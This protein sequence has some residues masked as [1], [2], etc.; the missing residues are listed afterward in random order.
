ML[1]CGRSADFDTVSALRSDFIRAMIPI[2][3]IL[4]LVVTVI[5]GGKGRMGR[6]WLR[7][8][9]GATGA[10]TTTTTESPN[11]LNLIDAVAVQKCNRR[12]RAI[13]N[14]RCR[15]QMIG[16]LI[17]VAMSLDDL[18]SAPK[19]WGSRLCQNSGLNES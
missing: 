10:T 5:V 19:P 2:I 12:R 8:P 16:A 15:S 4:I 3:A 11:V 17:A 14:L 9:A 6:I 18:N 7:I 13:L 1:A